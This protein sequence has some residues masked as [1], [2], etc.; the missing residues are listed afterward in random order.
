LLASLT[1]CLLFLAATPTALAQEPG[2]L[3][4][5]PTA[6]Q[7]L[8]HFGDGSDPVQVLGR[9]AAALNILER[10]FFRSSALMT[11]AVQAHPA[12][13]RVQQDYSQAFL[14]L[15]EQYGAAVGGIDDQKQR[16]WSEMC[17]NRGLDRPVS[18]DEVLALVPSSV[19]A[20]YAAAYARS[21]SLVAANQS[22]E[23]AAA[24]AASERTVQEEHARTRQAAENS[25]F[26]AIALVLLAA[27]VVIFAAAGRTMHR[28][29]KYRFENMTDGGVV[30]YATYSAAIRQSLVGKLS[31]FGLLVG[32]LTVVA[33][34]VMLLSTF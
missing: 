5:L 16:T 30:Q 21:D 23:E 8:A 26:R 11:S 15:R 33:G 29:G 32:G 31:A 19:Q 24:V 1:S 3:G 10:R 2:Y 13:R 20:G 9:Q 22:R 7:V 34:M 6:A 25:E 27:G 18:L 17:D 28:I 14:R 12:T 4:N